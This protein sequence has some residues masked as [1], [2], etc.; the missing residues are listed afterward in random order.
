MS[1]DPN[2][3]EAIR[4]SLQKG[5]TASTKGEVMKLEPGKKYVVRLL[6]YSKN[7]GKTFHEVVSF[8]FDSKKDGTNKFYYSPET[9]GGHDALSAARRLLYKANK[10]EEAKKISRKVVTLV[11]VFVI[12]DETNKEN[13]GKVKI[14]KLNKPLM[15]KVNLTLAHEDGQARIFDLGADG[16]NFEITVVK[17]GE[18]PNY[19]QS[20]FSFPK[21]IKGLTDADRERI[22][23][24]TFDLTAV[25]TA[26]T[27]EQV[28]AIVA[29][30]WNVDANHQVAPAA[31]AAPAAKIDA[32]AETR[33]LL[34]S[35]GIQ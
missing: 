14:L 16:R 35:M 22:L 33:N 17:K 19:D 15:E 9:N 1:L 6:P 10:E 12:S 34:A 25:Y 7:P 31:P 2:M 29:E 28:Q 11:N 20:G 27:S 8:S 13:E 21:P 18:F 26:S 5:K 23:D 24:S 30:H 4:S 32:D 3:F